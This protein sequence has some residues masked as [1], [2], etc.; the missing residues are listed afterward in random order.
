MHA[1]DLVLTRLVAG[2]GVEAVGD[3][4]LDQLGARGLVLDKP[5]TGA[6]ERVLVAHGALQFR[7][8]HAPA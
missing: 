3:Q 1:H 5:D 2:D 8:F 7:V 4:L 6:L